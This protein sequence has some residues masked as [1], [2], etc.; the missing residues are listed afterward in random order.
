[1]DKDR[2][3]ERTERRSGTERRKSDDPNYRGPERRSRLDRRILINRRNAGG[4][5]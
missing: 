1:M 4:K 2:R 5:E 3:S